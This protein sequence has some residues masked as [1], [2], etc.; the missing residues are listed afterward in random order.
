MVYELNLGVQELIILAVIGFLLVGSV[1]AVLFMVLRGK[2]R[3]DSRE[4]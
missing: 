3:D 4:G 2:G 1:V